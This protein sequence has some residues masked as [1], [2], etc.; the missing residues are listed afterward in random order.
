MRNDNS[1]YA[2]EGL[3]RLKDSGVAWARVHRHP[4]ASIGDTERPLV[5]G[6]TGRTVTEVLPYDGGRQVTVYL[7]PAS[8][9]AVVF[10]S[11][12]PA[13]AEWGDLVAAANTP[14]TAIVA[15][16]GLPD[17]RQRLEEYS[18]AF[19]EERFAAHEMFFVEEVRT[20]VR[21]TFD[22]NMPSE[23][24]AIFGAS[25]GGELSIALGLRHPDVY[26]VIL[27]GSP[28][29][30]YKPPQSLPV[31]IPRTYLVAG[32][33]EPFFLQNAERWA[34]ALENAGGEVLLAQRDANHAPGLWRDEFPR[35]VERAFA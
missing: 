9:S 1:R 35:M 33:Q 17:E 15:V 2:H 31:H 23:R 3:K 8:P 22:I 32:T 26:G 30:G 14:P 19:N 21:E 24:T 4:Q 18:P 12:G 29:A 28:G 34:R 16:H 27:T 5:S 10:T 20:W 6:T 7:P 11:D 25:A 13:A